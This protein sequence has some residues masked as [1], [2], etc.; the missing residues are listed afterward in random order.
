M[1]IDDLSINENKMRITF[2]THKRAILIAI[3][4]G[5]G[6]LNPLTGIYEKPISESYRGKAAK[7]AEEYGFTPI[8]TTTFSKAI[9][10]LEIKD[11]IIGVITCDW[12]DDA[13]D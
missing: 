3:S 8:I 4:G 2:L 13:P 7:I 6:L 9:S 5:N 11:D 1:V 12:L 10:I